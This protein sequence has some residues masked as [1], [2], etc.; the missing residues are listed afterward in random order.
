MHGEQQLDDLAAG[1]GVKIAGRLVGEQDR[2]LDDQGTGERNALLL[3]AGQFGWIMAGAP[4]QTD[5]GELLRGPL[6]GVGATGQLE[7]HRDVLERRHVLD[8][9]EGLEDDPHIA[10]AEAGQPVLV[11]AREILAGD[12]HQSGIGRLQSGR[13]HEERRFAGSRRPDDANRLA[14][15]YVEA[16]TLEH[17][18]P[19]GAAAE[20]QMHVLET[21]GDMRHAM[22]LPRWRDGRDDGQDSLRRYGAIGR[23]VQAMLGGL[24]AAAFLAA[25]AA[26]EPIRLV[27]L[28]DS[29][30]AGYDLPPSAA[31]PARLEAALRARGHDVVI[32]NAGVSG[33]TARAGLERLDWSV[34]DGTEGVIVELGANDALRGIDPARTHADLDA[35]VARLTERGI[36][37]LIAGMLAPRNLGEAY[38]AAF[39]GM[40]AEIAGRHG[41][42]LYPFFLEG[43]ATDPAL[44]LADGIHPNADGVEVIVSRI[45]PYVEGLIARIAARRARDSGG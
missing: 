9:V 31:F 18:D 32:A 8:E 35:I 25:P 40:F 2:R 28:G 30:T 43:V 19:G 23:L 22:M 5:P 29:L 13:H 34:P 14:G 16:Y 4:G 3:A 17:V 38:R 1:A 45:L 26:S 41:A 10:T 44:N 21:D 42:L 12:L 33:D 7:R 27:A 37:V 39:D 24:V 11:K 36:E 15:A 20:A 6:E